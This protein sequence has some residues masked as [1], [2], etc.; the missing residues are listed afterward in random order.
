MSTA[1]GTTQPRSRT[2]QPGGYTLC[3]QAGETAIHEVATKAG[4][5]RFR[6]VARSP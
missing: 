6:R 1:A 2:P 4:L 5:T 3:A